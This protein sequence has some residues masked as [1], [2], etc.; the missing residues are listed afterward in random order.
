MEPNRYD[1]IINT[2]VRFWYPEKNIYYVDSFEFVFD[3][4]QE[5][6]GYHNVPPK[7]WNGWVM[8]VLSWYN[9]LGLALLSTMIG[10]TTLDLQINQSIFKSE[11]PKS[12]GDRPRSPMGL[13]TQKSGPW[14]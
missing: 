11:N 12:L 3:L 8:D 14:F 2:F 13:R 9:Y 10:T 1:I 7:S 4:S 6:V 5:T